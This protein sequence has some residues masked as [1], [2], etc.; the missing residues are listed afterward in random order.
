MPLDPGM[1]KSRWIYLLIV[2]LLTPSFFWIAQDYHVWPWDQAWYGEVS[3]DLRFWLTHSPYTWVATMA[4]GLDL[5][6]PGVVWIG[7]FFVLLNG[8]LGSSERSLLFS[9]LATQFVLLVLVF[10]CGQT[11]SPDSRLVPIAG[12]LF[13]AAGQ[14]LTGLSHQFFVEPLQAVAVAWMFLIALKAR[15]WSKSR[16]A[17]HL[18]GGLTLGLLAKATT[19]VYSLFPCLY[20]LFV[21]VR[22]PSDNSL[23]T[24]W[25]SRSFRVLAVAIGCSVLVGAVWYLR[26]LAA[27]WRHVHDATSGDIALDYATPGSSFDRL[28]IWTFVLKQSFLDPYLVWALVP[29]LVLAVIWT[30][31]RASFSRKLD[32]VASISVVQIALLLWVFAINTTVDPRYMYA[33]LAP[34]A[35]LFMQLC[36]TL[37]WQATLS[38][39]VLC[40]LQWGAVS[41]ASLGRPDQLGRQSQWLYPPQRDRSQFDELTHIVRSTSDV[42]GRYNMFAVEE[43]WINANSASFFAASARLHTGVRSYF[44]SIGYAQKDTAAAMRRIE[45]FRTRYVITLAE[46]FHTN[47]PNFLN[48]VALPVLEQMRRDARFTQQDFPTQNGVLVFRFNPAFASN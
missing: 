13:A 44:T 48:V 36:A 24:E 6:P 3:V 37:P 40:V 46:P 21:W 7:Q 32:P 17:L 45:E 14:L 38:L 5:K 19:P 29:A 26:H 25:R 34:L 41:S 10:K 47:P 27:V 35:I 18:V 30:W 23:A 4:D 43:P 39:L 11:I 22:R 1:H 42:S 15:Q 9:I 2:G 8:I 16:I 12:V 31:K 20:C 28:K 33:I